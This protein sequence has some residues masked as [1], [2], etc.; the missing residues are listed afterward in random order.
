[1]THTLVVAQLSLNLGAGRRLVWA[2]D[3]L[4]WFW[5]LSGLVALALLV[6]LYRFERRLV[7]RRAGGTLLALRLLAA[8]ALLAAL[9]DPIAERQF[10][11][12]VR[13]RIV[14]GVDLSESM[15]T[16]DPARTASELESLARTLRLK[17]DE[18]VDRLTRREVV[19]RLLT[20]DWLDRLSK[21]VDV[22]VVGFAEQP[23]VDVPPSALAARLGQTS[24]APEF[25]A[26]RTDWRPVL[27]RALQHP[28]DT[29]ILGVVMLTDGRQNVASGTDPDSMADRLAARGIPVSSILIGAAAPPRDAAIVSVRVPE[30]VVQGDEADID[31][32]L[33]ID[34]EV[35][36][37]ELPVILSREGAE[38][39]TKLVKVPAGGERPSAAFR[40]PLEEAGVQAMTV[41]VGPM[42]GDTRP[43]NDKRGFSIEVADDSTR[44]LL[45]EAEARWEFR[46][47]RNA[48]ERDPHVRV[49]SVVLRQPPVADSSAPTYATN[50]AAESTE[51]PD[52][53]NEFDLILIGDVPAGEAQA[54]F[55]RRL[56]SYVDRRGGTLAFCAGRR[57]LDS[58]TRDE[59]ARRLMPVIDPTPLDVDSAQL[60]SD[61]PALPAGVKLAPV[62]E[63]AAES[64]PMIRF[65]AEPVRSLAVWDTLPRQPWVLAS[66]LKSAA[67]SLV[68]AD[69]DG[70]ESGHASV[71]AAMPYGLGQV[72][73]I[74]TDSTWRWRYRAGDAYH[75]RF[76]GQVVRWAG[77]GRLTAGNSL[78]KF[79]PA[80]PRVTEGQGI[81]LRARF[82]EDAPR[83]G[84]GTLIAARIFR[85][86]PLAAREEGDRAGPEPEGDAL[87]VVP[88]RP[89]PLQPRMFEGVAPGLP[90]G[91][92]SVTLEA[93]GFPG[94]PADRAALE[95]ST[96]ASSERVELAAAR[97]PLERLAHITG[98]RVHDAADAFALIDA[99]ESRD[100]KRVRV[101]SSPVW[102][103][104]AA[105][106]AF[107]GLLTA[108]WALRKSVGLP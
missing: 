37:T 108:E 34:G 48:L 29:P 40:V 22:D 92:Y 11:E 103:R 4:A 43:D 55:W 7:S 6:V 53:L 77:A 100:T 102:D 75:H 78:V 79:G 95:V 25:G 58:W 107:F 88:L 60:D 18:P 26:G 65:A 45:V 30:R 101:E 15:D 17:P 56:E 99:L 68:R 14:L 91:L 61:R 27:E 82:A 63:T 8:S 83:V 28:G 9:F 19:R 67:T 66:R 31:V 21:R 104:P 44:V 62:P 84:P 96:A 105:L 23:L 1:M 49:D 71:I 32:T 2:V 36:G 74:G 93:P 87:A 41:A 97:E 46:Y 35:P 64:W 98:G 12:D 70:V 5:L 73:W 3:G 39:V 51:A 59:I 72:F 89:S 81:S 57:A 54:T 80:R 69:H 13:G 10:I 76:W 38:P 85:A 90:G 42:T 86:K 24:I 94:M 20:G 52:P 106:L 16:V 47:L 33:K 50:V